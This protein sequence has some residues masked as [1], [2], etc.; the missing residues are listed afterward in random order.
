[1]RSRICSISFGLLAAAM[2]C[3]GL[4]TVLDV[5]WPNILSALRFQLV[6]IPSSVVPMIA[7]SDDWTIAAS[8]GV[9][10]LSRSQEST[11]RREAPCVPDRRTGGLFAAL[12][13]AGLAALQL[14]LFVIP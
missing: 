8:S 3:I 7:A 13:L 11:G 9:A 2:I 6:T 14:D 12:G 5:V 4:P 10:M 1:M